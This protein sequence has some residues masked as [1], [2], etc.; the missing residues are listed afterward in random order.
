MA[1][2]KSVVAP[3]AE[4]SVPELAQR[5]KDQL[6][7]MEETANRVKQ[8]ILKQALDLGGLLLQA[9]AK[10]GHGRFGK[11]LEK[12]CDL[13]ERSAQRY[14][15]LKEQWPKIAAWLKNNSATVADL[16]L[17][18]AEKIIAL[19]TL[20]QSNVSSTNVSSTTTSDS[21]DKIAERLITSLEKMKPDEAEPAAQETIRK[22]AHTVSVKK[23]QDWVPSIV[24]LAFVLVIL[25]PSQSLALEPSPP[26]GACQINSGLNTGKTG[27]YDTKQDPGH[28]YCCTNRGEDCTECLGNACKSVHA[29]GGTNRP[30]SAGTNSGSSGGGN[31]GVGVGPRDGDATRPTGY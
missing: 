23:G 26:S 28:V 10:V 22:L 19:P 12:N 18:Q 13:S 20:D 16:S 2:I 21:Y 30:P 17:R 24:L 5:I 6:K 8:T 3:S 1:D 25:S 11:W 4:L 15:A 7:D 14:M 29:R 27:T 31:T 9:K